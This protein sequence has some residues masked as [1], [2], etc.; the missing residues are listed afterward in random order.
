MNF[1]RNI[2]QPMAKTM[3]LLSDFVFIC[4]ANLTIARRDANLAHIR[5][6]IKP[7]TDL[8]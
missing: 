6:G 8:L 1:N 5:S 3:E 4:M 7:D 2:S